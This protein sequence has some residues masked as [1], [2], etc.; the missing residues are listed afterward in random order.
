MKTSPAAFT[1]V[2]VLVVIAVIAVMATVALPNV[3]NIVGTA[4][5]SR[6]Q[7]NAQSL[8]GLASSARSAG[9]PGWPTKSAAIAA[10][11]TGVAVTNSA[12]SSSVI[13]FR[14][15]TISAADQAKASAYL[16]SDGVS[17]VY[18]SSGG[19]STTAPRARGGGGLTTP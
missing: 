17:L 4:N 10:L 7:R 19:Q 3:V 13:Q 14:M 8:A 2:E 5:N 1:I 16:L 11:V 6:D 12:D 18:V 15:D 9:H